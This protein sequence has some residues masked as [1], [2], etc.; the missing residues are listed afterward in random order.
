MPKKAS[1]THT[2]KTLLKCFLFPCNI[3]IKIFAAEDGVRAS[4]SVNGRG[5]DSA[6]V[7]CALAARVKPAQA[8][9]LIK[10]I[11]HNSDRGG[12]AGL[13]CREHG[14]GAVKAL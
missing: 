1:Q 11:A 2:S 4:D 8:D 9:A 5:Y 13:G 3:P 6:C 10:F 14:I 7:A 12:G